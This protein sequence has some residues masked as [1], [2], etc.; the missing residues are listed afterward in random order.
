MKKVKNLDF[1]SS[2]CFSEFRHV[3]HL[4]E[5]HQ[6][7][8][9]VSL[10][11]RA[12]AGGNRAGRGCRRRGA[13]EALAVPR[14]SQLLAGQSQ[15]PELDHSLAQAQRRRQQRERGGQGVEDFVPAVVRHV[16][17]RLLDRLHQGRPARDRLAFRPPPHHEMNAAETKKKQKTPR[18]ARRRML[19][20]ATVSRL[21]PVRATVTA[22]DYR[23]NIY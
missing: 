8:Q 16:E 6:Q 9:L 12:H 4:T 17:H 7:H 14:H 5:P 21:A 19:N 2:N 3:L 10:S 18:A 11:A 13:Q 23:W 22:M 15:I 1:F 20:L